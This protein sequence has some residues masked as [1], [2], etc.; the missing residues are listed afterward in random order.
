MTKCPWPDCKST[1]IQEQRDDV[2]IGG[3]L[4]CRSC[5][6]EA[7]AESLAARQSREPAQHWCQCEW[8]GDRV[9]RICGEHVRAVRQ[10]P[11][12]AP[13][14]VEKLVEALIADKRGGCDEQCD[15]RDD[16]IKD[17]P[18]NCGYEAVRDALAA[19][20]SAPAEEPHGTCGDCAK[21]TIGP[22]RGFVRC[23]DAHSIGFQSSVEIDSPH[24]CDRWEKA[25][26]G[27]GESDG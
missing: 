3:E 11:E 5:A 19:V 6:E 10:S 13:A 16:F 9:V 2:Q 20:E 15:T 21:T 8:E 25:D 23:D 14:A 24:Y 27:E 17:L 12:P 22:L 26:E 1:K 7:A 4:W 18:C